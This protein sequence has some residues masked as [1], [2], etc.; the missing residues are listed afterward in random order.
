[1]TVSAVLD[2]AGRRRSPATMLGYHAGRAPRNTTSRW[3]SGWSMRAARTRRAAGACW[4]SARKGVVWVVAGPAGRTSASEPKATEARPRRGA[5][6][7]AMIETRG[8]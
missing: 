4:L 3:V 1:M 2:A 7:E 6:L 8:A 5:E